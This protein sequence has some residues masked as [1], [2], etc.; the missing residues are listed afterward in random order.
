MESD[1]KGANS[2]VLGTV[3]SLLRTS[4]CLIA[5]GTAVIENWES[6]D[7]AEAVTL[8]SATISDAQ[9]LVSELRQVTPHSRQPKGDSAKQFKAIVGGIP[10][11]CAVFK[12]IRVTRLMRD[13]GLKS[14][15][16]V[17][18][19]T[20]SDLAWYRTEN[21]SSLE[22]GSINHLPITPSRLRFI[23]Y[24]PVEEF[25]WDER[26]RVNKQNTKG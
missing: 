7:L 9:E 13:Q 21:H 23:R 12:L 1:K 20:I 25:P 10:Q 17:R 2:S 14:G 26:R 3:D 22:N 4:E 11:Y 15:Q 5:S 18:F 16:E 6:G 24:E 19:Y 8:L